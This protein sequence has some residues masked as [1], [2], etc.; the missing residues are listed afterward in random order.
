[1]LR[2]TLIFL[3][4]LLLSPAAFGQN[5][6]EFKVLDK[7]TGEP[8][9]G[10]SISFGNGIGNI[11]DTT[12]FAQIDGIPDGVNQISV[13]F[14]G[15]QTYELNLEFPNSLGIQIIELTGGEELEEVIVTTTRS[16]RMIEDIPTRIELISSEEL[17]EKS[18]MKSSNIAML[19]REST[20][21]LMQQT[22]ASSAN[23]S[24]RIQGLDGRYTQILKDGFPLY[25]AFSSGLSIMQIPPLDLKQVEVIKGSNSTLYGGGA[26]AGLVNLVTY[27]PGEERNLRIMLDQSFAGGSTINGFY[28]QRFI[29]TGVSFYVSANRQEA[30]DPNNDAFS[31]I[32]RI[33]SLTLNPSLY[34]YFNETA[35]LR[36][37]LN[38]TFENRLGGDMEMIKNDQQGVYPFTEENESERY[39]YQL[40]FLKNFTSNSSLQIKNSLSFF[41]RLISESNYTFS[42]EQYSSFSEISYSVNSD[43]TDWVAGMNIY[44]DQ[45]TETPFDTLDRSYSH[46]TI[47]GFFQNNYFINNTFSLETGFRADHSFEFGLFALPRLSLLTHFNKTWSFRIGG[48]LGYKLPTIFTEDA[49]SLTYQNV[50]PI[51]T[52]AFQGEKS[53][54]GNFDINYKIFFGDDWTLSWNQLFFITKVKDALVFR[55]NGL[56]QYFYENADGPVTSQGLET[57]IKLTFRDFKLFANYAYIHT[58]LNY[59]NLN[60]QKPLTPRHNIGTVLMYE[61]EGKWR[62]GYEAYYKGQQFRNDGTQT[63]DYW[64]MGFMMLRKLNK[65]SL[66]LNFENFTDTRQHNLENFD[67]R[68]HFKPE[69]PEIWAPTDG[70]VIN[71]GFILEL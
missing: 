4:F 66:Y 48:G 2:Y 5:K 10:A 39:S 3:I 16:S 69:F 15:Y 62:I 41:D 6:M 25:G 63:T 57:N 24:I 70:F 31:D 71:L 17:F 64:T 67:I 61:E 42:A 1:M 52:D 35:S 11:T 68:S 43:R 13:S 50:L 58:L 33:R 60:R 26:I 55:E 40:S 18:A 34:Y 12:G 54:G 19:L 36:L 14:V 59:D 45:F 20:G 32:P 65:I 44:T 49:E 8:L 9:T 38:S 51:T 37:T 29:K 30:Y 22:S 46:S 27:Q 23:Q 53:T 28:A 47:G 56:G 21:I 7:K